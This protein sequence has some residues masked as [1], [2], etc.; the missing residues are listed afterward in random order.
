MLAAAISRFAPALDG[1][2]SGFLLDPGFEAI[3]ERDARD[4]Q[5]R[6]PSRHPRWFTTAYFH[7]A[8]ELASEVAS[9]LVHEVARRSGR[10]A[11]VAE[12]KAIP[13]GA[14]AAREVGRVSQSA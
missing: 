11:V 7:R 10:R 8:D 4:G 5:H 6:N 9:A 3:V 1:P 12:H 2:R 13:D 14:P